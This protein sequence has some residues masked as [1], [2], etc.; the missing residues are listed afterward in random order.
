QTFLNENDSFGIVDPTLN[1][2]CLNADGSSNTD[3]T[4]TN[5]TQCGGP[6]NPG[7]SSNPNFNSLLLPVDL[8]RGGSLFPFTG[9]TDIKLLSL[10]AQDAITKGNFTL[11]LGLRGDMYNGFVS[12]NEAEPRLGI[13]YNIKRTNT[14]LRVS[15]ARLLET[16]F[17]ENLIISSVG[18]ANSVLNPL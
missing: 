7:G 10:Y 14:V 6:Q 11:N 13:A 16:P 5:Q 9:H 4:I 1:A 15:Y 8:T 3:P 2:V 12:H 18:C 17:N